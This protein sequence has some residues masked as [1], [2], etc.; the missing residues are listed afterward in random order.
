MC[1]PAF[2]VSVILK[3]PRR[4]CLELCS[5]NVS[6]LK[7]F[8]C[9]SGISGIISVE[10][11]PHPPSLSSAPPLPTPPL[12]RVCYLLLPSR[13]CV[14]AGNGSRTLS[15]NFFYFLQ[16]ISADRKARGGGRGG[17]GPG[18]DKAVCC[19]AYR[20]C[21]ASPPLVFLLFIVVVTGQM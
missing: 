2:A 21:G 16:W 9:N 20:Q 10:A 6:G 15:C 13:L 3:S 17:L 5:L 7:S 4:S 19:L 14:T 11:K 18:A 12:C 8:P 1:F